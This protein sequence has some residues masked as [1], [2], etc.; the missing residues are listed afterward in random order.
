MNSIILAERFL[1]SVTLTF[2]RIII[3][4][5]QKVLFDHIWSYC[6]LDL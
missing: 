4:E 1:A 6:D 2:K 3:F 5:I